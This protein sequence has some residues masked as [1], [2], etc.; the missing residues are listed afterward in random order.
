MKN[1]VAAAAA[2]GMLCAACGATSGN[3][4]AVTPSASSAGN[5]QAVFVECSAAAGA[6][7]T[8]ALVDAPASGC[9]E[10]I[11]GRDY[12]DGRVIVG[13][14]PGTTESE[15]SQTLTAYHATVISSQPALADR[16][17]AVPAGSVPQ[18][19]VGLARYP[20]VAFAAPDMLNHIDQSKT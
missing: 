1:F 17:L 5:S 7:A 15:L 9:R 8:Y 20:F 12:A 16:V 18:A 2:G 19:V 13:L 6:S 14:K 10:L 3:L 11:A 4:Q